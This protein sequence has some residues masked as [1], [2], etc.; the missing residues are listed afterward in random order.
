MPEYEAQALQA[1]DLVREIVEPI[2]A[3]LHLIEAR[4][5]TRDSAIGKIIKKGYGLPGRQMTDLVAVRVICYYA[6]DVDRIAGPLLAQLEIDPTR[7]VDKRNDLG[8]RQFGYRSVHLIAKAGATQARRYPALANRWFEIQVRSLLEHSWAEIE[9]QVVY[10]SGVV[11]PEMTTRRFSALAATLEMI[12]SSFV[13]LRY[14]ERNLVDAYAAT[15]S[16][17]GDVDTPLDAA[18]LGGLMQADHPA[19]PGWK[20]GAAPASALPRYGARLVEALNLAGFRTARDVRDQLAR[21]V[22]K[23]AIADY[24]AASGLAV[25]EVSQ[26]AVLLLAVGSKDAGILMECFPHEVHDPGVRAALALV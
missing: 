12:D 5:K 10:K 25:A 14:E 19:R 13:A 2:G 24:A 15:Y 7:T 20:A 16:S 8:L 23:T 11:F 4:A 3:D 9:H 21:P 6:E 18:R 17:G 26:I 22:L 1:N